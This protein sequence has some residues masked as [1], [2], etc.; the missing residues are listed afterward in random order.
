TAK[1]LNGQ[2]AEVAVY[3]KQIAFN[4]IPHIDVFQDNG[5]TKEEMV[6]IGKTPFAGILPNNYCNSDLGSSNNLSANCKKM[7][8][9]ILILAHNQ[10]QHLAKLVEYL[11]CDWTQI[12]IHIDK[13]V[14]ITNFQ[15]LT[16]KNQPI[17]LNSE[18]RIRVNWGGFSVIQATLNLLNVALNAD[19][20]DRFCLLSGADFPIKSLDKIKASFDSDDEFIQ[21]GW[22][23]DAAHNAYKSVKYYHFMDSRFGKITNRLPKIPRK[24]YAKI[25]L[26]KGAQWWSL[27]QNCVNYIIEFLQNNDDYIAFHKFSKCS[28]E[29]FF[30]S[31]IQSSPFVLKAQSDYHYAD[32]NTKGVSLPKILDSSDFD[33]LR[34]SDKLFARKFDE[35]AS[36]DLL[37]KIT[38]VIGNAS[39]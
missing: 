10:P 3:P 29:I 11:S 9:A 33:I 31:I 18:Q 36:K 35:F 5:Y 37:Q 24:I 8:V 30:N 34:N 39:S 17:F 20:F 4:V 28:D 22:Q 14:D 2:E 19:N 25:T 7:K 27:T 12:F 21:I 6:R 38:K 13:K 32:W 1:L 26:Y 16:N 15:K 23:L